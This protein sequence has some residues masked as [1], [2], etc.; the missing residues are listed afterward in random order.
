[1]SRIKYILFDAANTLIHKPDL[2]PKYLGVLNNH[3]YHVSE[4]ELK[5]KHKLLSEVIKFPDV[6]S[7]AFYNTFNTELLNA[8]GIIASETLLSDVFNACKYLPWEAF[9]DVKHLVKLKTYKF[10]VLS[11][12]NTT[13]RGLLTEKLPDIEFMHVCISEEENVAKPHTKFF[14]IAI[15]KIGLEA[16]EILYI[17]DSL[18]L[19]VI[20]AIKLGLDAKLIDRDYMYPSSVYR[21]D[22]FKALK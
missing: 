7:E 10:G 1:M 17:G 4:K 11:N 6:T 12:F 14:K 9:D 20:P 2:W 3:G 22:S 15:D 16:H 8:L 21:I 18:K 13:L 19:D 5:S